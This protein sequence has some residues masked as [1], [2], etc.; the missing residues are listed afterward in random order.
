MIVLAATIGAPLL[1]AIAIVTNAL[2]SRAERQ[3]SRALA[4][5]ART[6]DLHAQFYEDALRYMRLVL[7]HADRVL[8]DDA[9]TSPPAA[10]EEEELRVTARGALFGSPPVVDE[11]KTF[12]SKM[13]GFFFQASV[14]ANHKRSGS[15]TDEAT[16][17]MS[18]YRDD[19]GEILLEVET[20]MREELESL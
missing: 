14:R 17:T 12:F 10:L 4:R 15:D 1:A 16:R 9:N 19:A 11:I 18:R 2:T 8:D 5:S 3:H 7:R 20:M 6:F 13:R